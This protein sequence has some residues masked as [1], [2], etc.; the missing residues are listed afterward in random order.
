[1]T[2][3]VIEIRSTATGYEVAV[4]PADLQYPVQ[5]FAD[6]RQ[7]FGCAGGLRIVTGFRKVDLTGGGADVIHG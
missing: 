3:P 4:V 2:D 1:M 6:K 7:A 5:T